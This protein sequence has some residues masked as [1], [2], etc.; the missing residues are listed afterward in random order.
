M[1]VE[2]S[3]KKEPLKG[4]FSSSEPG[5]VDDRKII[6]RSSGKIKEETWSN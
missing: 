1:P 3:K 4:K 2:G 6:Q 5:D